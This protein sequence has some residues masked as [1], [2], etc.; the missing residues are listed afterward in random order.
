MNKNHLFHAQTS[1]YELLITFILDNQFINKTNYKL[2]L[3]FKTLK[4]E[5]E[6]RFIASLQ[7]EI[8]FPQITV[9]LFASNDALEND[10]LLID[11]THQL[12]LTI[13]ALSPKIF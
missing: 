5:V 11:A 9:F 7:G 12:V 1:H 3:V 6:T 4:C 2:L 8:A 10:V 13:I